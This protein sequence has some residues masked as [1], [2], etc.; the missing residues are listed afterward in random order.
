[1]GAISPQKLQALCCMLVRNE[2]FKPYISP[3]QTSQGLMLI[4][5]F[6]KLDLLLV[7]FF[8]CPIFGI[9]FDANHFH[10]ITCTILRNIWG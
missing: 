10:L 8:C 6:L 7:L 3:S 2:D 5:L 4:F 1:M 9:L